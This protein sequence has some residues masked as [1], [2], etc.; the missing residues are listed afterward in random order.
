MDAHQTMV[1]VVLQAKSNAETPSKSASDRSDAMVLKLA[2]SAVAATTFTHF[3][4]RRPFESGR[5]CFRHFVALSEGGFS[6]I[7]HLDP[8]LVRRGFGIVFVVPVPPLVRRG[9]GV[10]LRRVFPQFLPPECCHIEIAPDG[11]HRLVATAVDEVGAEHLVAIADEG[12]M[13]V[14]L[15]H[16]EV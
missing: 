6:S 3:L 11:P 9:L 8:L 5:S 14:P 15:V 4:V 1:S 16:A 7:G 2:G 10:A 12:V 13:A